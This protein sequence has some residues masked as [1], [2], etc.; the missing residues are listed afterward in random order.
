MSENMNVE[1]YRNGDEIPKVHD[2]DEWGNL[3]SGAWCYYKYN[4]ENGKIYGKLY[5]WY[6]VHDP[7]GLAPEGWHIPS[8]AEWAQ[9][10]D[11][12][13]GKEIAGGKLKSKS[14]WKKPNKGATNSSGFSGLPSGNFHFNKYFTDIGIYAGYWT[15]SEKD[16]YNAYFYVL[17]Y[18]TIDVSHFD[19]GW[20]KSEGMSIRCVKD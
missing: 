19:N 17:Y 4:S 6:A 3:N 12:L 16:E 9:L 15:D 10:V 13:G 2:P 5:N 20:N 1:H 18:S 7:R 8:D 14:L 11:Y